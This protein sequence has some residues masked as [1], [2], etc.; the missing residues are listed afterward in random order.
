M[1]VFQCQAGG[2]IKVKATLLKTTSLPISSW[3]DFPT[4][5]IF[6]INITAQNAPAITKPIKRILLSFTIALTGKL[7]A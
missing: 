2:T 7:I 5:S 3:F 4:F 6:G 1:G